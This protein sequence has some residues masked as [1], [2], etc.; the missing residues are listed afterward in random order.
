MP[1]AS[2]PTTPQSRQNRAPVVQLTHFGGSSNDFGMEAR[3]NSKAPTPEWQAETQFSPTRRSLGARQSTAS[4]AYD[5]DCNYLDV[6]VVAPNSPGANKL[7]PQ[8]SSNAGRAPMLTGMP[9]L[10]HA[11][12]LGVPSELGQRQYVG[13]GGLLGGMTNPYGF[14]AVSTAV[15]L[16]ACVLLAAGYMCATDL[17]G[18]THP[19]GDMGMFLAV[20]FL[21]FGALFL[22]LTAMYATKY[23]LHYA[24]G[25]LPSEEQ[26]HF[27]KLIKLATNNSQRTG[28]W[29]PI[30]S[31]RA[32]RRNSKQ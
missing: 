26:V 2:S 16:F 15:V 23:Y 8:R 28:P 17:E 14:G 20:P 21:G 6:A 3:E 12:S 9:Y 13:A 4:E 18:K 29:G 27:N 1:P 10:S 32:G 5:E 25:D 11:S 24:R 19:F 30:F 22:G 31:A 7:A